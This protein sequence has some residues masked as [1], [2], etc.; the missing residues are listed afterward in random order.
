M[1]SN[2]KPYSEYNVVTNILI[3]HPLTLALSHEGR[4]DLEQALTKGRNG[5]S[6]QSMV[7]FST[8][9][10]MKITVARGKLADA[11]AELLA[12][13]CTPRDGTTPPRAQLHGHDDG[14][15]LD[16]ALDGR[17]AAVI[18]REEFSGALGTMK[19]IAVDR[20]LPARY[21]VLLGAGDP[22][23]W[24]TNTLRRLGA[25]LTAAADQVKARSAAGVLALDTLRDL[26]ATLRAQALAEGLVL[27]QYKFDRFKAEKDRR[28][29][30]LQQVTMLIA[31]GGTAAIDKACDKGLRYA[32]ATCLAR[33]L[34]NTPSN[35]CTPACLAAEAKALAKTNKLDCT[36]YTGEALDKLRM[37]L[38][39]TVGRGSPNAPQFIH[40]RY[41]PAGKPKKKIALVGKGVT[42]DTGG[43]DLKPGRSMI[44]MKNDMGGAAILLAV[45]QL[46]A[47]A[48]PRTQVDLYI[49]SCENMIGETTY[50]SSDIYTARNGKTIEISNTDAE[51]RLILADALDV[52]AEDKPD[53]ILDAAT[54]TGGVQY[55]VGELY[56]PVLGNRQALIDKFLACGPIAG[57][58][59]WQLPLELEYLDLLKSPVAEL[60]NQAP[61]GASTITGALFLSQFVRDIPW[62]HLDVAESSWYDEDRPFTPR[63]GTG[64]PARSIVEF[65]LQL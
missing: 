3:L 62:V 9:A 50:K 39:T 27:G 55:A 65:V 23:K 60:K 2:K 5:T 46:I 16:H 54:L 25:M 58:K 63:G 61:G 20:D 64:N 36:I 31:R 34:I 44:T 19:L 14:V 18:D 30:S 59:L 24:T 37:P 29:P 4:G 7:R 35:I 15:A 51:G 52:A 48:K 42:F 28:T 6:L 56:T 57:D 45:I 8:D 47:Q 11:T 26:P 21:V 38:L 49:P 53:L 33:D 12:V 17:L 10:R 43:Y 22:K 32:Q 13:V 1:D 40:L 41:R